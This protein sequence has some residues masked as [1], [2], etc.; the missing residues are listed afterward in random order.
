MN[1][2]ARI[3]GKSQARLRIAVVGT[4]IAGLSASWLLA[5]GHDVTVFEKSGRLGGH[6][7]TVDVPLSGVTVPVDTGFIVFNAHTYPNLTALFQHLGVA[8]QTSEMSFGVSLE[9]G[10]LEYSGGTLVG[11]FAQWRNIARPRFWS[12]VTGLVRFYREAPR[13][14]EELERSGQ[15][16]G[17]LLDERGYGLPFRDDHLLP[18][19]GAIWSAA[20][21]AML[22]YPAASFVRF[23]LN[24][25][26]LQLTNRP[27][28]RTVTGGSRVYVN[29]LVQSMAAKVRLNA[30]VHKIERTTAGVELIGD[31]GQRESFDHVVI[32][33]HA[34]QA[35]AM[36]AMPSPEERAVL[37][38]IR[39]S[40]NLAVL[41][42][43]ASLMPQRRKAWSSWNVMRG[44]T[45]DDT[46]LCVTYWM[47]RLQALN[48]TQDLFV[49]L[50]PQ[51]FPK[52]DDILHTEVYQHPVF[53][54]GALAAQKKLWPLQGLGNTW[55]CGAYF[56]A[57][58]HEDGLQS[59]L[60]VAEELGGIMRPWSVAG[61]SD[62]IHV[63][64]RPAPAL[65]PSQMT[66]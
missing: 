51:P 66:S 31:A 43:D 20:P 12:M 64:A 48:V 16:L 58:F 8:T 62:R 55:F 32:A 38:G 27:L 59:G 49:T 22:D 33:A 13:Q 11:L 39:Y 53:D 17:Q 63:T 4:G 30:A 50:N 36:L 41:H 23:F 61:Q 1:A 29:K 10:L 60:A 24:H 6:S 34:D 46:T 54:G 37:G 25:G 3:D 19:A 42:A 18:M 47:N 15:T 9:D 45:G 7:N 65:Q 57:G 14:L 52:G 5:Q 40:R 28:W 35:L 56:G 26:L 21:V 44:A 2:S